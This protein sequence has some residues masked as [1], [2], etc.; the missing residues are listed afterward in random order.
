[1]ARERTSFAVPRL[2]WRGIAAGVLALVVAGIVIIARLPDGGGA[3]EPRGAVGRSAPAAAGTASPGLPASPEPDDGA[4]EAAA[5]YTQRAAAGA[6]DAGTRFVKA[7]ADHPDGISAEAWSAR[8]AKH[9]DP[10]LGKQL[11]FTDPQLVPATAVTG[12]AQSVA[13]GVSS[14]S[15]AVPTDAGKVILTCT[16]VGGRW[17]VSDLD[18]ERR[19]G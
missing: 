10:A 8:V 18:I 16:L 2:S 1:M 9:A 7:W 12:T 17:L 3:G 11:A 4:E 15:V 13:G 5:P 19:P 6:L 14:A